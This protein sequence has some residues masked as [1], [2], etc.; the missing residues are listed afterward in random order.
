MIYVYPAD[1]KTNFLILRNYYTND[2]ELKRVK[3]NKY[4]SKYG[5]FVIY[6]S[7]PGGMHL[8]GYYRMLPK[9]EDIPNIMKREYHMIKKHLN[10]RATADYIQDTL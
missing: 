3:E 2:S 4:N 1:K 10:Y 6:E 5:K 9:T 7:N 8:I